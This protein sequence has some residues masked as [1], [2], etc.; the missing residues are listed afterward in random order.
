MVH[1]DPRGLADIYLL[2]EGDLALGIGAEAAAGIVVDTDDV[3]KSGIF[4]SMGAGWGLNVGAGGGI[5]YAPR[6]IEGASWGADVNV[7]PVSFA[8]L[9]DAEGWNGGAV[10]FGP[11]ISPVPFG[12]QQTLAAVTGT[13]T[14]EGTAADLKSF[15]N[16]LKMIW[17]ARN[18]PCE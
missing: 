8:P 6:D 14:V 10:T 9:F 5:G 4:G 16:D 7:G 18:L 11:R 13:I 2:G 3:G 15:W 1:V 12:A 17:N